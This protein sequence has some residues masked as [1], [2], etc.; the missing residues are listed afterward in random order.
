ME[1][2]LHSGVGSLDS[3][4]LSTP[5]MSDHGSHTAYPTQ[6]PR[7]INVPNRS[8]HPGCQTVVAG[9]GK[10]SRSDTMTLH[11]VSGPKSNA[12]TKLISPPEVNN[13]MGLAKPI[14]PLTAR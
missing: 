10:I 4:T 3:W 13:S 11:L 2:H 5:T 9:T 8:G 7:C 1:A 12:M 6:P 14:P